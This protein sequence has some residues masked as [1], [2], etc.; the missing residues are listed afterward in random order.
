LVNWTIAFGSLVLLTLE[1]T[2]F[3]KVRPDIG[4]FFNS[5]CGIQFKS[6]VMTQTLD[7]YYK[8]IHTVN[9]TPFCLPLTIEFIDI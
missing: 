2:S 6:H 1:L 7:H 4:W 3:I 5:V 8:K 9:K